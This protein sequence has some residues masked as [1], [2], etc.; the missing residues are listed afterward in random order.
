[1]QTEMAVIQLTPYRTVRLE[2]IMTNWYLFYGTQKFMPVFKTTQHLS[3]SQVR[4]I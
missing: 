4:Q 2:K 3:L 1:M